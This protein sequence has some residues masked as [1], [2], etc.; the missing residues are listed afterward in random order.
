VG[1]LLDGHGKCVSLASIYS[2]EEMDKPKKSRQIV[3][4][5]LRKSRNT[6]KYIIARQTLKPEKEPIELTKHHRRNL[7]QGKAI[8]VY[9][10]FV[11]HYK[12]LHYKWEKL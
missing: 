4:G 11:L 1:I 9:D 7:I 8:L 2:E 12:R 10:T 6:M 3:I 5:K